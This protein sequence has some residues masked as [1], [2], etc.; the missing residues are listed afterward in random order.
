M[1]LKSLTIALLTLGLVASVPAVKMAIAQT[2]PADTAEFL[3]QMEACDRV[4]QAEANDTFDGSAFFD[5]FK[6]LNLTDEQ[7]S[8]YEVFDTQAAARRAEV[9]KDIVSMA[10][11]TADP[12]FCLVRRLRVLS[13]RDSSSN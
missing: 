8:A 1:K 3:R 2:E 7:R 6:G 12:I 11:P 13:T 10:D 5:D 9:Y 4:T